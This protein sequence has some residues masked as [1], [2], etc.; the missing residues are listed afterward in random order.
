MVLS[1][2]S[3]TSSRSPKS[4]GSSLDFLEVELG[5]FQNLDASAVEIGEQVFELAAG[6]K[7][8]GEQLV[9]FVVQNESLFFAHFHE[10]F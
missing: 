8:F 6:G 1:P 7:F 2:V 10:M 5:L 3:W 9:D 4:S